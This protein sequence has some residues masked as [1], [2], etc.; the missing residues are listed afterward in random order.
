ML[1]I[2]PISKRLIAICCSLPLMFVQFRISQLR[3]RIK[4]INL[5]VD[6]S[7]DVN[8]VY[9]LGFARPTSRAR[10]SRERT[11]TTG[12]ANPQFPFVSGNEM[13]VSSSWDNDQSIDASRQLIN[14]HTSCVKRQFMNR[15]ALCEFVHGV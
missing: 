12:E 15:I 11:Q 4:I 3:L 10:Y 1:N 9:A 8:R 6:L 13:C 5:F 14:I 2:F 7:F